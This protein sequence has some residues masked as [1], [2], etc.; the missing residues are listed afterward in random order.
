MLEEPHGQCRIGSPLIQFISR[1]DTLLEWNTANGIALSDTVFVGTRDPLEYFCQP[2][3]LRGVLRGIEQHSRLSVLAEGV[4]PRCR[5]CQ[6]TRTISVVK[7]QDFGTLSH[8][9]I[10]G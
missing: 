2:I 8:F 1:K 5:A 10:L 4:G 3:W 6:R 9:R 7:A